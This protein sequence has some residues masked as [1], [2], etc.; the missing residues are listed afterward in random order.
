MP[1][2]QQCVKE[3]P[4]N[5]IVSPLSVANALALLSQGASGK[6]FEQLQ[7]GLHLGND[8]SATAN[9][10]YEN[11]EILKKNAAGATLEVVNQ[12]YVQQGHELNKNFQDVAVSKF[13]SGVEALNFAETQKS[14]DAINHFVEEKTHGKIKKLI[15]A[16]DLDATTR[17][18]LVNALYFKGK[19]DHEFLKQYTR[20]GDFY[21]SETEKVSVDF[22]YATHDFKHAYLEDLDASA[23]ELKYANS[24]LAF[25]IVSP[26]QRTGL[27]AV[28]TKLKDYDLTKITDKM[29]EH[30][31]GL[32]MPKFK[33]EYDIKLTSVL[34]NVSV[35]FYIQSSSLLCKVKNVF[36]FHLAG[37]G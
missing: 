37:H 34:T 6:T 35:N 5:V 10:F 2:S 11:C 21:T 13:K 18:V 27:S 25:T 9:Q 20:K 29:F 36:Y 24:S 15:N 16:E 30:T 3:K 8:K 31:V 7:H 23:I 28:E 1:P 26:N 14:A 22:M 32:T 4:G 33:I 17:S 19:W 12:V